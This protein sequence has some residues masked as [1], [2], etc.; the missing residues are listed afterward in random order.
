VLPKILKPVS[1][2]DLVRVGADH[3][4]GYVISKKI[5]DNTATILTFGLA[6]EFSFEVH[7]KDLNKN[8]SIY[9][10]DHTVNKFYW[11]KH[12]FKWSWWA[13]RYR[14]SMSRAFTFIK[15]KNFFDNKNAF[16]LKKKIV[17]NKDINK[18]STSISQIINK[19]QIDTKKT[20][21][22]VD[23]DMDEYKILDE[24][25]EQNFLGLIIEFSY[26]DKMLDE[27]VNFVKR[28]TK[29]SIIHIHGNN[30]DSP[31]D[32]GNPIHLEIT[33]LKNELLEND[34][35]ILSLKDLP[36]KDLDYPNNVMKNDIPIKF[37]DN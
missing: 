1:C 30:F 22:K 5:V 16:H 2:K 13:I 26:V 31:N 17:P 20:L 9:A 37:F 8:L 7:F 24:I 18:K 14:K 34:E 25:L 23:I 10:F 3:D 35:K 32:D 12:F 33:F 29:M 6:D 28:N 36:L 21:L 19:Y 27:A 15:Y 4:G 11:F